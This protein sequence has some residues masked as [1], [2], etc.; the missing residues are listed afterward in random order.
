MRIPLRGSD[1]PIGYELIRNY[2]IFRP[3]LA[4]GTLR[5][6]LDSGN[7][8]LGEADQYRALHCLVRRNAQPHAR[9][10]QREITDY[11][12]ASIGLDP[13]HLNAR[14]RRW[15][16]GERASR[17]Y[18]SIRG[19]QDEVSRRLGPGIGGDGRNRPSMG[20]HHHAGRVEKIWHKGIVCAP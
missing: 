6:W 9:F 15:T 10:T 7:A 16:D 14:M 13:L 19:A 1:N 3:G 5:E 20:T 2:P 11:L 18:E 8:R 4:C 12:A 17:D